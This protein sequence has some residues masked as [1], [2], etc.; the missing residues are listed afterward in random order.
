MHK[1]VYRTP[2]AA[3]VPSRAIPLVLVCAVAVF[4]PYGARV[5][6]GAQMPDALYG[7]GLWVVGLSALFARWRLG[8]GLSWAA[9]VAGA[10]VPLAVL[11]KILR[12]VIEDPA[13]HGLWPFELAIA[14]PIGLATGLLGAAAGWVMAV[15]VPPRSA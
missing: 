7:F 14:A 11:A 8:F 4:L 1:P 15:L 10:G 5:D 13:S 2:S 9:F 12:D 3:P 6:L